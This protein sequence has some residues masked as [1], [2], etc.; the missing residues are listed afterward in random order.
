MRNP[1]ERIHVATKI[2]VAIMLSNKLKQPFLFYFSQIGL[3]IILIEHTC[4]TKWYGGGREEAG[5][6]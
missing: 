2:H 4:I 6:N 3:L 1:K 5:G